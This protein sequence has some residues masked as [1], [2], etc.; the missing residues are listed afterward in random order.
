MYLL[1][2]SDQSPEESTFITLGST[3]NVY[4]AKVKKRPSCNCPDFE[5]NQTC[6]KHLLFIFLKVLRIPE[7]ATV[8]LLTEGELSSRQVEGALQ[9]RGGGSAG[10]PVEVVEAYLASASRSGGGEESSSS[11]SSSAAGG[12]KAGKGKSKSRPPLPADWECA[13][14]FEGE[15]GPGGENIL[16][17]VEFCPQCRNGMHCL[18]IEVWLERKGRDGQ[19]RSCPLCRGEWR[20]LGNETGSGGT[21]R[22]RKRRDAERTSGISGGRYVN[23][24]QFCPEIEEQRKRAEEENRWYTRR[25]VSA[26]R[27]A[28]QL[29]AA[30]WGEDWEAAQRQPRGSRGYR[31]ERAGG[32]G[33]RAR[34]EA[35]NSVGDVESSMQEPHS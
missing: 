21:K 14:C 15:K 16:G 17:G 12:D 2:R 32:L 29:E 27:L 13:I 35:D 28:Q 18:C 9:R 22:G 20:L 1:E 3:G 11:S 30:Q 19:T 33:G 25:R 31:G 24:A 6:C 10:A 8:S 5:R 23:L 4:E 7:E 34:G 26:S